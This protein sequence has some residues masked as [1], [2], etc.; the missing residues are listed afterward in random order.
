MNNPQRH[1]RNEFYHILFFSEFSNCTSFRLKYFFVFSLTFFG[2][3]FKFV[4]EI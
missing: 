4:D 2:N 3:F 1:L